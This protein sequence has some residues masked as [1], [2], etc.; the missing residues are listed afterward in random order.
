VIISTATVSLLTLLS[1][2]SGFIIQRR[3]S[4]VTKY[5]FYILLTGM[6]I[7]PAIVPTYFVA[8]YLHLTGG[9]WGLCAVLFSLNFS[10][11]VFLYVGYFK[12][13]PTELDES[14]VIDGCGPYRLFFNIIFP[15]LKPITVTVIIID[16]MAVWNDFGVSIYFLHGAEKYT[17]VLSTFYYFG[18][19]SAEWNLVFANVV[20]TSLPVIALYFLL[21]KYIISGMVSGS[22]KG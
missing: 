19:K 22:L 8:K 1:A 13:I 18:E 10:V 3:K 7:P 17:M 20:L 14:A 21:Q 2:F 15:L 5:S 6:M 9:Y 4:A 12:S 11:S 16:F